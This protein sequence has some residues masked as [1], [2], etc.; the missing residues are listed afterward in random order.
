M[1]VIVVPADAPSAEVFVVNVSGPEKLVMSISS[2]SLFS[3]I[4][5]FLSLERFAVTPVLPEK[6][7]IVLAKF[8]KSVVS[9]DA[10]IVALLFMPGLLLRVKEISPFFF[11]GGNFTLVIALASTPRLVA[12]VL[13]NPATYPA[14]DSMGTEIFSDFP[15]EVEFTVKV[16]AALTW[17]AGTVEAA[18]CALAAA[19][20]AP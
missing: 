8:V 15:V 17:L 16:Y 9:T 6:L 11:G 3:K 20:F 18:L 10:E 12:L 4:M 14:D 1:C 5:C 19:P 2:P 7:F 13:I